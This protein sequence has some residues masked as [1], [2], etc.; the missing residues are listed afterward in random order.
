MLGQGSACARGFKWSGCIVRIRLWLSPLRKGGFGTRPRYLIAQ[1]EGGVPIGRRSM[2]TP[3]PTTAAT[4][5]TAAERGPH[6][7]ARTTRQRLCTHPHR[8]APPHRPRT[9]PAQVQ[10]RGDRA[11]PERQHVPQ[12]HQRTA[13]DLAVQGRQRRGRRG[14]CAGAA[15][16]PRRA[17]HCAGGGVGGQRGRKG[18]GRPRDRKAVRPRCQ[19]ARLDLCRAHA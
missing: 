17:G 16:L 3:R 2:Y 14:T 19:A 18:A 9:D 10:S 8:A 11:R 5:S 13:Q 4:D 15:A 12:P 6:G 7:A 1:G